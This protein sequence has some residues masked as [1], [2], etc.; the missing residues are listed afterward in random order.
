MTNL[1][2]AR[3]RIANSSHE[4]VIV[5]PGLPGPSWARVR[6]RAAGP[7]QQPGAFDA[8]VSCAS[9]AF[10]AASCRLKLYLSEVNRLGTLE[11]MEETN[12]NVLCRRDHVKIDS[13]YLSILIKKISSSSI[14]VTYVPFWFV[15]ESVG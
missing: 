6:A 9:D 1:I 15:K 13:H 8:T 3:G 7:H 2:I 11:V 12:N 4:V 10:R 5:C 14:T